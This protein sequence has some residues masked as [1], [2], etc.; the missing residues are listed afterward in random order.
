MVS[1][2]VAEAV[3]LM[4]LPLYCTCIRLQI[5]LFQL[6]CF[7]NDGVQFEKKEIFTFGLSLK[8][9]L[10][11]SR[12]T[13]CFQGYKRFQVVSRKEKKLHASILSINICW[14]QPVK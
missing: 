14:T 10:V 6:F 1:T 13:A 12:F 9:H 8:V 11:F 4:H 3:L 7:R 2:K 5:S